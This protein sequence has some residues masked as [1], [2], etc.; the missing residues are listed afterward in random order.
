MLTSTDIAFLIELTSSVTIQR[1][2]N[3]ALNGGLVDASDDFL[4]R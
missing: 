3:F 4:S 2:I 1:S